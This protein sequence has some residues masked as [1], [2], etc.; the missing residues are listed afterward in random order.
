MVNVGV[1]RVSIGAAAIAGAFALAACG[2]G[3]SQP[4]AN[5]ANTAVGAGAVGGAGG[6]GVSDVSKQRS[7]AAGKSGT[8][9]KSA[10]DSTPRCTTADLSASLGSPTQHQD[11]AGQFDVPLK[12]TNTSSHSCAL[13]GVPGVDLVGPDDPNGTTYHLP[14]ID[15]G[16][17]MNVVEPGQ[18]A[19]ATVTVLTQTPGSVGSLGSTGWTPTRLVTI[20]PGQ[21]QPLTV[22]WPS[23]LTVMRQDSAT[24]PGSFV[25]GILAD[26]S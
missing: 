13:H 12:Y 2:S 22:A 26:P 24:H 21:T 8:A 25:N 20:P 19:T 17:P 16:V 10:A 3:A 4:A 11:A 18:S 1:K 7:D 6:G 23:S 14:R 15:N 5:S 9:P